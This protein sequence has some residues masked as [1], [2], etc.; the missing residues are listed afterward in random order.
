MLKCCKRMNILAIDTSSDVCSVAVLKDK[1][2]EQRCELSPQRHGQYVIPTVEALLIQQELRLKDLDLIAFGSGPGSYTGL[3]IGA[4]VVQGLAFGADVPVL[5]VSSL[6]AIAHQ[7][8][9][10]TGEKA[11]LICQDARMQEL[12]WAGYRL[13]EATGL[14][15]AVIP[16]Q[17]ANPSSISLS[18]EDKWLAVGDGWGQYPEL[19]NR[20][21]KHSV[22]FG[23]EKV[24]TEAKTLAKIAERLFCDGLVL[25]PPEDA[26]PTYLRQATAWKKIN[27]QQ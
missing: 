1:L 18:H 16:E 14:M 21:A 11:V 12:Y 2:V 9:D 7:V 22:A 24:N 25:L 20:M 4:S 8:F 13:D 17:L 23:P 3:R 5:P 27:D 19:R 15:E 10:L 26:L 6:R